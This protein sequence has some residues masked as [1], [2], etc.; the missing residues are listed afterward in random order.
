MHGLAG[1]N[2]IPEQ[3]LQAATLDGAGAVRRFWSVK[4]P[5]PAPAVTFN[6]VVSLDGA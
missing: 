6:V 2:R 1:V 5:L 4:L 3:L